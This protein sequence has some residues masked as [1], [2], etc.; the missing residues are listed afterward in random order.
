MRERRRALHSLDRGL[1]IL[2]LLS[3]RAYS[4]GELSR[5][6]RCPVS[7]TYRTL[8]TLRRRNLVDRDPRQARYLL[9]FGILRFTHNLF[10]RLPIREVALT[11]MQEIAELVGETA[12]L[13]VRNGTF[14]VAVETIET[15]EPVRVAPAIGENFPLHCGAPMKAILA[16]LSP[17]EIEAYLRR[18]LKAMTR[19][20]ITDP[21]RLRKHLAEVRERGYADSWEEVYPTAVGVA[22]PILG[23]EGWATASLGIAGPVHRFTPERVERIAER[24]LP[25]AKDLTQK[26]LAGHLRHRVTPRKMVT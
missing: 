7:T 24:L 22:A 14:G 26:I 16:F 5:A 18:R 11:S 25:A 8:T 3:E 6:L 19:R 12:V 21:K 23:V 20:T 9:G 1:E 15:S 4:V 10:S 17:D 13:T 2:H